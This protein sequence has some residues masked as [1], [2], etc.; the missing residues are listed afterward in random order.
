VLGY[1]PR[2]DS[3]QALHEALTWLAVNGQVDV[4]GQ[5]F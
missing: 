2:Y 3:L 1:A 5:S 4:G